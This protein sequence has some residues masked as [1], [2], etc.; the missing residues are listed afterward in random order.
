MKFKLLL[1]VLV[2]GFTQVGTAQIG[3]LALSPLQ[4]LEQNIAKTDIT[5]VYSRPAMRERVVFGELV[6]YGKV[7]RTG[8][9]Q[10]TTISLSED[11]IVN[12]TVLKKGKYAIFTKPSQ[13]EWEVYFYTDTDGWGVPET[14][15]AEKIVAKI[16]VPSKQLPKAVQT[17]SISID[18]FTN[19][20]FDLGIKWEN[21][22]V[23]IPF[24]LTTREM[25]DKLVEDVLTGPKAGDYYSAATYELESGKDFE[26]GLQQINKTIELRPE[27]VWYDFR[28]KAK[29][30]MALNRKG[31]IKAVV[32]KGLEL[33]KKD[34]AYANGQFTQILALLK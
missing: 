30:L 1:I 9:N 16:T 19:Y 13:K 8:A 15:D 23:T 14:L 4:T 22:Q 6:P 10:N 25:M 34:D 11:V 2:L 24:E 27:A 31:E 20:N 33:V 32:A 3:R 21:T 5:I 7:W 17:L 18:D 12:K 29:L 26:K 28:T